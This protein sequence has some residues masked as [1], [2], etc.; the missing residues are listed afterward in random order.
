KKVS[1]SP[2]LLRELG[3]REVADPHGACALSDL[4]EDIVFGRQALRMELVLVSLP[5]VGQI[6]RLLQTDGVPIRP[7]NDSLEPYLARSVGLGAELDAVGRTFLEIIEYYC[8]G[9]VPIDAI[10]GGDSDPTT[11]PYGSH[12][13]LRVTSQVEHEPAVGFY[14]HGPT[15]GMG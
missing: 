3:E 8:D 14:R 11:I 1:E 12:G 9:H 2:F 4:E 7:I 5:V 15:H 10:G 13:C 6:N